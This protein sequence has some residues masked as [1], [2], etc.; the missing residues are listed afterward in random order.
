MT[1]NIQMMTELLHL[2]SDAWKIEIKST[3]LRLSNILES[4]QDESSCKQMIEEWMDQILAESKLSS[5]RRRATKVVKE[6]L[7]N[8]GD[9]M[10]EA[11]EE[12]TISLDTISLLWQGYNKDANICHPDF[13]NEMYQ[14]F[15]VVE[16]IDEIFVEEISLNEEMSRWESGHDARVIEVM[17][18]NKERIIQLLV[19]DIHK[20]SCKSSYTGKFVFEKDWSREDCLAK[21]EEWWGYHRFHLAMAIKDPDNLNRYLGH[22]LSLEVMERLHRAKRKGIPF[23]VTPYYLSLLDVS[24]RGY[25]DR[26]VRDYVIYSDDLINNFGSIKAWERED[27]VKPGEANAAGWILPNSHAVH[28]RYPEVAILIPDTM[29]RACG[30]L[31]ASC[32]RMYGFQK[33]NLNFDLEAL[34]PKTGWLDNLHI[35][36]EYFEHDSQLR[37]ILITG[38]DALMSR[39]KT[40]KILLDKVCEMAQRKNEANALRP[41][42]EKYA[43][44]ERVRL[45][46]RLPAYLP[47]RINDNLIEILKS[48]KRKAME[49]GIKQFI[50]Q[51]HFQSPLEVTPEAVEAVRKLIE[52]GWVVVNQMVFTV[53]A[54]RRGHTAKLRQVLNQIGVMCYYTFSVKGFDEN[55]A[56]FVPN[57]RSIQEQHEE[58]IAGNLTAWQA[59]MLDEILSESDDKIKEINKFMQEQSLPFLSTDRSV[60]N[61]P[62]IGK[63]MTFKM[64]AVDNMGRRLLAFSHDHTRKHSPIIDDYPNVFI[65]ERK[66]I[67]QYLRDIDALGESVDEYTSIWD[68]RSAT[69]ESRFKF[70]EYPPKGDGFTSKITNI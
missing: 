46:T 51:T 53:P 58:K 29:G 17:K 27:V 55:K 21:V 47:T 34:K 28:R 3:L 32:Q 63:S 49:Q 11:S 68:Y 62:G 36:L 44:M 20:A 65:R 2:T 52:A 24:S 48:F 33:G 7:K 10:F 43:S 6:I 54:S 31:C 69:T 57:A 25:D 9:S 15:K 4:A 50:I 1:K 5:R 23:F 61:L 30:G 22:T 70:Y 8:S 26:S 39:N 38:G 56:L 19:D 64:I 12:K 67:A 14:L 60:M 42:G 37:D 59:D 41:D 13:Y 16:G 18:V 35:C 66:S 40:L 45:G